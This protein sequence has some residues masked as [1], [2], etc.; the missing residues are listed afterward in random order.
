MKFFLDSFI[1]LL[2]LVPPTSRWI[3][4]CAI[5]ASGTYYETHKA[6]QADS[7]ALIDTYTGIVQFEAA[8]AAQND[9][10]K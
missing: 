4:I 10:N 6:A 3:V 2:K 1:E 7:D 5:I 9:C 8:Q